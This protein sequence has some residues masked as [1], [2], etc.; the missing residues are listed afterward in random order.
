MTRRQLSKSRRPPRIGPALRALLD[1]R[2]LTHAELAQALGVHEGNV[3]RWVRN[4]TGPTKR[5]LRQI[6]E[7]FDVPPASLVQSDDDKPLAA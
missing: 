7:Y 3:S 1:E 2:F 4:E 5:R 6:A